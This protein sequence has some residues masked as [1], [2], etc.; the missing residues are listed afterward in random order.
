MTPLDTETTPATTISAEALRAMLESDEPVT[1]LD[2][3]SAADRAEWAIPGSLHVDAYEALKAGDPFALAGADFPRERPVVTVCGAGRVSLVA[4]EQL[5]GRG[6]D[7]RS[8]DGGMKAWSL[9]WNAA[10]AP[11][12]GSPATVVQV[13]RTGK[14]C[15][16]YLVG[17][18]D[19]AVVIDPALDPAVYQGL[20]AAHGWTITRVL[21]T[22]VHADH[23]SRSR[24]LAAAAD[25]DLSL[26]DQERV[27]FPFG[28]IRDGDVIVFGSGSP[29]R[30][31]ALR[32]PGHT[33]ESTSYL[34]D[35]SVLFTGDTLFLAGVGRPD[36]E[37]SPEEAQVRARLLHAALSTLTALPAETVVLPGHTDA[38]VPFDGVPIA[39]TLAQVIERVTMLGLPEEAFV[40]AIL[41][42][43][44]PTPPNHARIVGLNERGDDFGGDPTD[45][46]AGANRCAVA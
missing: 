14:G 22:H 11:T 25:A 8:L 18:G 44:P 29:S 46:E 35:G 36:L 38:P 43:I 28:P 15:L 39:A 40:A 37:A 7:A 5:R 30:L 12:P 4:M 33:M 13:R 23:L 9:A 6:F 21:D 10:K 26:P 24:Q 31:V 16:S 34:L 41:S 1:I 42:R 45:L 3:R 20:A 27:S 2:V 17:N 19:E 32:T